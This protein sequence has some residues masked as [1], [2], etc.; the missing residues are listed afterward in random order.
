MS[1]EG[2][3]EKLESHQDLDP[4]Q[5]A[6]IEVSWRLGKDNLGGCGDSATISH[7]FYYLTDH[8]KS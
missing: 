2:Q 7:P 4:D 5:G 1:L 8:N 3:I 6:T